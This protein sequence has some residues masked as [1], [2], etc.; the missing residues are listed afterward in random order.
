MILRIIRANADIVPMD[1]SMMSPAQRAVMSSF[2]PMIY[3]RKNE[4]FEKYGASK[5]FTNIVNEKKRVAKHAEDFLYVRVRAI[6]A[7]EA[8]CQ[9]VQQGYRCTCG[10]AGIKVNNNGDAF[11]E[12]E[13]KASYKSFISK[14]NFVDH[15]SDEVDKIRGI[16]LDAYWNT[17]GRYVECLIAVDKYSHP[18]LARDIETGVIH[19]VSMG[20]Q[21]SESECSACGNK[22]QKESDYCACIKN[23]KGL[24][25]SG[26]MIYEV[27]RGLNFIELSWVTNPADPQCVS[28]Q[29][30]A[31]QKADLQRR[32]LNLNRQVRFEKIK[33]MGF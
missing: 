31:T 15:K 12:K 16:V 18:Q 20:C 13:L 6:T 26:S 14:G 29:K 8:G 22:A 5:K 23:Y 1:M 28:M 24:R 4:E 3:G 2:S 25:R 30:I 27:N 9:C 32:Q 33:Q 10:A 21:V 11:P 17:K 19:G 7:M